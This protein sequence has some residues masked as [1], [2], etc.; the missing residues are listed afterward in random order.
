M[1]R[2]RMGY[3]PTDPDNIAHILRGIQFP[4]GVT[5]NVFD[6]CCGCGKA[7]RQIAQGN[8]CFAYGVELDEFRADEAQTRLHRVGVGSFFRSRISSEVFHLMFLNPPYMSVMTEGGSRTRHEKRFLM[9]SI[10]HLMQGGLLI[11]IIPFYRLTPDICKILA[12]NFSDLGVWRFTDSE[13][14]KFKQV[15]VMGLRKK[16]AETIPMQLQSL[17]GSHT[18]HRSFHSSRRLRKAVTRCPLWQRA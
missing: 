17:S 7:L 10:C 9:D 18:T 3:Y 2:V 14:K 8:N 5:T 15:T 4:E 11:Y 13:F 6:P 16:N 1:N 12:D